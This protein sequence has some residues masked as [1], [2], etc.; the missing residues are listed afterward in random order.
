ME[1]MALSKQVNFLE[2]RVANMEKLRQRERFGEETYKT[3]PTPV[4]TALLLL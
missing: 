2:A 1:L 3:S 4:L